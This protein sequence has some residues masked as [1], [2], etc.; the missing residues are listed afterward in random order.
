MSSE[1]SET[2]PLVALASPIYGHIGEVDA[3][4]R[5]ARAIAGAGY[6]V[7]LLQA[8]NEWQTVDR[9]QL[10]ERMRVVDLKLNRYL[11]VIPSISRV[12]SW[13]HY[14]MWSALTALALVPAMRR[15][16][17]QTRPDALIARMLTAPLL[18]SSLLSGTGTPVILS[19]GGLPKSSPIRTAMWGRLYPKAAGFIAPTASVAETASEISGISHDRFEVIPNPVIDQSVIL[20]GD[21]SAPDHPWINDPEHPLILAVGRMTRQKDFGTLIRALKRVREHTP[22]RLLILGE[23]EHRGQLEELISSLDLNS[24]VLMPGFEPNPYRYMKAAD[25]FVMPSLW[26]G[27]GHVLIE[28]QAMGVP[29]VSTDCPA[30]PRDTLLDGAAGWLVP[31][32]DDK[33]MSEA[34]LDVFASPAEAQI[35]VQLGLEASTSY[36]ESNVGSK[37]ANYLDRLLPVNHS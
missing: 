33:K 31:V 28:A 1:N 8:W 37:W 10:P 26:E 11:P 16:L 27:P 12:S 4:P 23:G 21:E 2:K 7:D 22:A 34:I 15:Y 32:G 5:L 19:M 30:G 13:A 6:R 20:K 35:K 25:A 9:S 14:R 18:G 17:R 36:F 3:V 24:Y 29:A